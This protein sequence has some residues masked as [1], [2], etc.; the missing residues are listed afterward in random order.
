MPEVNMFEYLV[1]KL[2]TPS[3][4]IM[5][6]EERLQE[7]ENILPPWLLEFW[8]EYG[9]GSYRDGGLLVL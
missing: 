8:R 4:A 5:L 9:I 6:S 1:K 7:Y 3:D 2:G